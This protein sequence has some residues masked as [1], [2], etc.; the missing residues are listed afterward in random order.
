MLN[1][2]L[3]PR[4]ALTNR[5]VRCLAV[6]ALAILIGG[7]TVLAQ[8]PLEV[9]DE[10][11]QTEASAIHGISVNAATFNPD[12]NVYLL[13][14]AG[15]SG[16]D[17]GYV[18][19]NRD[20]YA[21]TIR[22]YGAAMVSA[23]QWQEAGPRVLAPLRNQATLRAQG[24]IAQ[25]ISVHVIVSNGMTDRW[26]LSGEEIEDYLQSDESIRV[27]ANEILRGSGLS[28][29][30]LVS[31]PSMTDPNA[32]DGVCLLVRYDAP[33]QAT[34]LQAPARVL[35]LAGEPQPRDEPRYSVPRPG[36]AGD[37]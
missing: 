10:V 22:Q 27:T 19:T 29:V 1:P 8:M 4:H 21:D 34:G 35:P 14:T 17:Y 31:L 12:L 16:A 13:C 11:Q 32:S 37:F 15:G 9:L 25:T 28:G 3:P 33:L 26:D 7:S 5:L 24:A 30:R 23:A 6:G 2:T 18:D 20:G 36:A